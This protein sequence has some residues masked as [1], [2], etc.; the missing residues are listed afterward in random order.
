MLA[1][2]PALASARGPEAV[3]DAR[4]VQVVVELQGPSASRSALPRSRGRLELDSAATLRRLVRIGV[5][6]HQVEGRIL[7]AVP[8]ASIRWRY[9]VVLNALAVV[10]PAGSVGALERIEGVAE[11][12]RSS[13]YRPMLDRS[14]ATIGAPT[15]WGPG[16]ATGGQGMKIAIID[17][18]VDHR[19]QFFNPAGYAMP[20]GFPKGQAAYTTAKVI[21]ARSFPPASPRP[22]YADLPF[23]PDE[24]EHGT[25]VG[26]IAAGNHG[27]QAL[28]GGG[29]LTLSGV[30]PRAYL[31]NY[32]VLTV[33]T[34][35]NV[36]LDGNSPEIAAGIEAAVRDGMDV[37]NLSIGEPE[38]EP[39]RDLVVR[40]IEGAARAGVVSVVAAGNDFGGLGRGSVSSPG[41][42]P[43]AITVGATDLQRQMAGFSGAGPTPL[44]LRL[45]PEVSAPG[46]SILSSTVP[47]NGTWEPLSGTS[48]ATPHIAGAAALLRQRHPTWR[49][50]QI[51]SALAT[52]GQPVRE[53]RGDATSTR[54]GGGFADLVRADRPALFATPSVVSFGMVRRGRTVSRR[55]GLTDA[56]GGAGEWIVAPPRGVSAAPRVTVP[57][58]LTLRLRGARLGDV[59][60]FVVLRRGPD[61][62]RIAL[63][64]RVTAPQLARHAARR[65]ARTGTY[66]GNTR[67][68]RGLVSIYRYPE[69]PTG[70]GVDR[71]LRGPEQVFRVRLRRPA[72]NFGVAILER[73][74][75][76]RVQ[77]RIVLGAD[78]NRLA[79]PTAL[80]LYGNPYLP[81]F[82]EPG[83][84]VGTIRPAA[85]TYH[86]V[87]DST[88]RRGA[89][90]F[91]FRL[92]IDDQRPPGVRMLGVRRGAVVFSASDAGAGVDPRSIFASI[93]GQGRTPTYSRVGNRVVIHVPIGRASAGRHRVRLQVSDHQESKNM[94]NALRILPNTTALE[95]TFS[96]G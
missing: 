29:R 68:R 57:G 90:R 38:I 52:T 58:T 64:G 19:H 79:G 7:D 85:G 13:L 23:D 4:L 3:V 25:H 92:W 78:E 49:P 45:K 72:A 6:Q 93:D 71:I 83:P 15:L 16:L 43:S 21:A 22:R 44:S 61:V 76:V 12:H 69:N 91:S 46:V 86:V 41:S 75:G 9:Q 95:R 62:R 84:V 50:A 54:Q 87:F 20:A 10:A 60:G 17:D 32:R 81:T 56:G 8:S 36:G 30:A 34:V 67:G 5:E 47:R 74:R 1:A 59:E 39:S 70:S 2:L 14:P 65:L 28:V 40:A 24:S 42:A 80:P 26:G 89:G 82:L 53:S 96:V 27:T 48:M 31:G 35:S 94:E 18:G 63:W 51:K 37:L 11:V 77:P 33:P 88:T 73:G 66:S 55:V